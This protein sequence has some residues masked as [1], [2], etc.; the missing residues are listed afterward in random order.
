MNPGRPTEPYDVNSIAPDQIESLEWYASP[1]Q[2]P[3]RYNNLN[4]VCGVIVIHT[5]RFESIKPP[6]DARR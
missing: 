6:A 4:S 3:S 1:S 2:T 5:R